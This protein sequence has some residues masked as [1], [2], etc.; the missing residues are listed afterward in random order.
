MSLR[1]VLLHFRRH[2]VGYVALFVALGGTSYAALGLRNHSIDPNKLNPR[3]IS[4]Y[5]RAWASVRS[6]G[7]VIS[8]SNHKVRVRMHRAPVPP[9]DFDVFWHTRPTSRCT[10]VVNVDA[11]APAPAGTAPGSA[12]AETSDFPRQGEVTTVLTYD[13]TGQAKTLPFDVALLC[14]TPH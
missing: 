13:G 1:T 10:A 12:V 11:R 4:G 14:T 2:A 3:R 5:V 6:N 7:T 8:S 9:G